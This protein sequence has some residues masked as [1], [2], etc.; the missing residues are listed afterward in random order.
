MNPDAELR[1]V[2]ALVIRRSGRFLVCQRPAH[3]NYPLKWEFPGG[4]VEP[5]ES[6]EQAARRELE[7]ELRLSLTRVSESLFT[8]DD[9]AGTFRIKFLNCEVSGEPIPLEHASIQW[10]NPDELQARLSEFAPSDQQFI[11]HHF[12]ITSAR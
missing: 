3:K 11:L 1:P 10:L 5:G 12:R 2:V 6:D 8:H 9:P 7:E 4:K